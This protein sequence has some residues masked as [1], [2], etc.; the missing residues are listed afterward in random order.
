MPDVASFGMLEPV[1]GT[2]T[3]L[4]IGHCHH[5][6]LSAANLAVLQQC[7][8]LQSMQWWQSVNN[9]ALA[10]ATVAQLMAQPSPLLPTLTCFEYKL[11]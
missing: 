9:G 10:D 5:P 8:R 3:E 1:Y 4:H 11:E 7:T 6:Q 2:L